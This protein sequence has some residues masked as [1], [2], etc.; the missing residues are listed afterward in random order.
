MD[1]A[2]QGSR[3]VGGAEQTLHEVVASVG[4]VSAVIAGIANASAEQS[5]GIEGV[6]Q[7]IVQ[8]DSANQQN[9]TLVEEASAAATSFEQEAAS[10]LDVVSRFKTDRCADRGRVIEMVK[11]AAAHL[12]KVGARRACDDFN[13]RNGPFVHGEYYIFAL[14]LDGR[15]LAYAPT[16][17]VSGA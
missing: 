12:R 16:C 15:R 7:A 4:E 3:M 1:S 6:N 13:D 11:Q 9:A 14:G 2:E 5:A 8:I 17:R 10:L